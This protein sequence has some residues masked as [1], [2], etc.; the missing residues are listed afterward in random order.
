[1]IGYPAT[2]VRFLKVTF[3]GHVAK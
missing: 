1:L 3:L 2:Q